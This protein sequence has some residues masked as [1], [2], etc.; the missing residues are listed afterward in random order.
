MSLVD[1]G[2]VVGAESPGRATAEPKEKLGLLAEANDG[3]D[4]AASKVYTS[5]EDKKSEKRITPM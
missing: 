3:V 1:T 4:E 5:Y 2:E